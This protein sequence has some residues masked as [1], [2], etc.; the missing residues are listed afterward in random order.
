MY[1]FSIKLFPTCGLSFGARKNQNSKKKGEKLLIHDAAADIGSFAVT[2]NF[3]RDGS[4]S[5][6]DF[7][8][9]FIVGANFV[10]TGFMVIETSKADAIHVVKIFFR[11]TFFFSSL[12]F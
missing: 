1:S 7:R 12:R 6:N 2:I 3:L 9:C 8:R 11:L 5:R 4:F 10:M